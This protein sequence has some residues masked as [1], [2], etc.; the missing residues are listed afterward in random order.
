MLSHRS[1]LRLSSNSVITRQGSVPPI[2]LAA[3]I[4]AER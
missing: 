3:I 4:E 1:C 2:V